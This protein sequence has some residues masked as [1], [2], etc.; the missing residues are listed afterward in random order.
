MKDNFLS[1]IVEQKKAKIERLKTSAPLS[2]TEV[3]RGEGKSR[4][5]GAFFNALNKEDRL[6]FIAEIKKAS[7]SKGI[8]R[9]EFDPVEIAI[10]YES[11]AAAAISVLTEEDHF[12]GS[13]DHLKLVR[14]NCSRP[15]LRKDFVV[16]PYQIYESVTAGA[17]AVLLV[18]AILDLQTLSQLL[19]AAR[20]VGLDALVEVHNMPELKMALQCGAEMIG[21]NNRDLKTF[22]VDLQVTVQL[23]PHVPD[24]VLLVSESGITTADDVRIL[25]EAGCDGFLVGELF[26]K[27]ES[28]GKALRELMIRSF[29]LSPNLERAR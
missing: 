14:Q 25:R 7:P 2:E 29:N 26:M 21:I 20:R 11:N 17:D 1:R 28:P 15:L 3:M 27:S 10:D 4:A 19:E 22:K 24:P 5:I 16:D 18:V 9:E 8:L 13:F 23:A 6:N 12:L